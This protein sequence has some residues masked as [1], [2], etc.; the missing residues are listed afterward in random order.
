MASAC[1]ARLRRSGSCS[2]RSIADTWLSTVRTE[3]NSASAICTFVRCRAMQGKDL[4][5]PR[6]QLR[7]LAGPTVVTPSSVAPP[8]DPGGRRTTTSSVL[9]TDVPD[10]CWARMCHP[11]PDGEPRLA[12]SP[13]PGSTI[14]Q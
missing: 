4:G 9:S 11:V 2:L 13:P 6:R 3:M 14:Q 8:A 12:A 7:A 1:R 10:P 5:L